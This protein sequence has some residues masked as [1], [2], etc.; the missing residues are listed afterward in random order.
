MNRNKLLKLIRQQNLWLIERSQRDELCPHQCKV[1]VRANMR[2]I[3]QLI[4]GLE[5]TELCEAYRSLT[6][7]GPYQ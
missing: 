7:F 1:R 6:A 3:H 2:L 4:R 5:S